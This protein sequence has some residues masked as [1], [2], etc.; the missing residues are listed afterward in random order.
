MLK[1]MPPEILAEIR[2]TRL[3]LNLNKDK[4]V[5]IMALLAHIDYVEHVSKQRLDH[6]VEI[7]N[8]C[9]NENNWTHEESMSDDGFHIYCEGVHTLQAMIKDYRED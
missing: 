8:F 3:V 6:I 4:D 2:A 1:P 9:D 7:D 5:I